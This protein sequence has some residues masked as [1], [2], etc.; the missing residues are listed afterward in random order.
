M[1]HGKN[2]YKSSIPKFWRLLSKC[3]LSL[4]TCSE[5]MSTVSALCAAVSVRGSREGAT[6][7]IINLLRDHT[8]V[9]FWFA[10]HFC[11]T[12]IMSLKN[13]GYFGIISAATADPSGQHKSEKKTTFGCWIQDPSRCFE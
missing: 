12:V 6:T 2:K 4:F 8:Q 13:H 1:T 9:N 5:I 3:I 10:I 7:I 11:K